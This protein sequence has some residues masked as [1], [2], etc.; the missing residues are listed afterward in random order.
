MNGVALAYAGVHQIF[1]LALAAHEVGE[2]EGLFCSIVDAEGS[3]GRRLGRWVPPGTARPLGSSGIPP[4]L[5]TEFPWPLLANRLCKKLMPDMRSEHLRSNACFDRAA[6]RW[7]RNSRARLFVGAESC[8]LESLRQAGRMGMKCVLDCPGVPYQILQ[9]EAQRAASK[10]DVKIKPGANSPVMAERKRQ[11]LAAADL[12]LCCSDFQRDHLVA[13]NSGIKRTAVIPLWTD[14]VF[15]SEGAQ[16]RFFSCPGEPLRVLYAGAVSLRKGVPYLL[17]AVEPLAREVTLTLVGEVSAEMAPIL[18][19][20]RSH[21][22]LPYLPRTQLR[23]LY[24]EHDILVMPTLGDSFGF[25]TIE[26]M[27]SGMPVIA[28]QNAGAPV[29]NESWRVPPHDAAAIGT[30]LLIYHKDR[31]RLRHD[32]QVAAAFG[33]R[34]H[35]ETYRARVGEIFKELLA[36]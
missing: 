21:R 3:W 27:A 9:A 32:G 5:M 23:E 33:S 35:P 36:A 4:D 24:C 6:S 28:T 29:P 10:F 16:E 8:A 11:E 26:A 15:W 12:V 20:C 30:K 34:F 7:L 19:R 13:L 14:V 1:Q 2:L 22:H 18:K 17:E 31:E 25:V